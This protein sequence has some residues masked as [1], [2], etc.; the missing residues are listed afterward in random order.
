MVWPYCHNWVLPVKTIAVVKNDKSMWKA[1]VYRGTSSHYDCDKRRGKNK[2]QRRCTN[3]GHIPLHQP[4]TEQHAEPVG[5]KKTT[6]ADDRSIVRT[7]KKNTN[8]AVSDITIR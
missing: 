5:K 1:D 6:T 8:T 4:Y 2:I 7:V 3:T